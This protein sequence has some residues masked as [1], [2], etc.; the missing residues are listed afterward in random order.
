MFEMMVDLLIRTVLHALIRK[1]GTVEHV[2]H[3]GNVAGKKLPAVYAR[4]S[5][6]PVM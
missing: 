5:R 2:G 4:Q 1:D 6:V 3:K